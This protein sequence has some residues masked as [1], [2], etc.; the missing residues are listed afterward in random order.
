MN[1]AG[2]VALGL[3]TVL[4][5]PEQTFR[6]EVDGVR[7]DVLVTDGRRSVRGLTA[8][9][10]E[11]RDRGVVQRIES[12]SFE[13]VPLSLML[14]LDTSASVRGEPLTHLREAAAA[15]V[16]HMHPGDRAAVMTFSGTVSLDC[17]WTDDRGRLLAALGRVE[18]GGA[19]ALHD[20]A[21]AGL[22]LRDP[23]PGRPL[24]LVFSDAADTASWLP[25][26]RVIELAQRLDAVV[27]AV[28]LSSPDRRALGYL[29]DFTSGIQPSLEHVA[30]VAFR[31][32]F[33][34]RLA[35]ETGGRVL[36]AEDSGQLRNAF[37]TTVAEFRTRYVITY[38]PRGV[39]AGGWHPLEVRVRSRPG[40][41]T[42]RRGY[43]R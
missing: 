37:E 42:A 13:D 29:A 39:D 8:A 11:V 40:R 7:V 16:E 19:T 1:P 22:I 33:V 3:V 18:A 10:F 25:G 15:L 4:A 26:A 32:S 35:G 12:V 21:Y 27:Y 28:T 5:A 2:V 24:V 31:E 20:A 14:V 17:D 30:P 6:V 43:L 34:G 38:I 23:L 41:V 36:S 9:D